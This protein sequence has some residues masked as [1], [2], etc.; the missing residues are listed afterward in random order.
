MARQKKTSNGYYRKTFMFG[1]KR[2]CVYGKDQR[3]LVE[4][5][6]LK[7]Q[8]LEEGVINHINPTLNSYYDYFTE[9]RI[10]EQRESTI[11]SQK[12]QFKLISDVKIS[13]YMTFGE[14]RIK[15][16]S[17]RDIETARQ[18]LLDHEKSPEYLNICFAH[19]NHVFEVA[20]MD[21]TIQKNPCKAL[22]VSANL[23]VGQMAH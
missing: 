12:V 19:L 7:R 23:N 16:I 4:K 8:E 21:D 14:M 5:L 11:R 3:E 22:N 2:Y 15:D 9:V 13:K 20:V 1:G 17:R 18:M 6:A 10:K